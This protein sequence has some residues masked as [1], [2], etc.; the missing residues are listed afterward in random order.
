[1]DTFTWGIIGPGNI[2]TEF[3]HDLDLIKTARHRVGA[4]LSHNLD[5][6]AAFAQKEDAPQYF[7]HINDFTSQAHIDAVYIATP[8]PL[9]HSETL[10]CLQHR[11]PVLCEKPLAMNS[12]QVKEIMDAAAQH[13]TFLMEG[14]WIRFLPS[15]GKVLSLIE[16]NAIGKI[17][18]VKADMSYKAPYD[19]ASRY[20]NPE[21]GG[22]SLLDLGIYPV[23]LTHL[24]LGKPATIQATARLSDKQVDEA[25]AAVL[26]YQNGSYAFI[27]SSLVT[28]TARKATIYGE[29]GSIH[30][31]TPWNEE[32]SGIKVVSYEGGEQ[33]YPCAWEGHGL[34]YEAEE[35]YHCVQQHKLY[36]HKHSHRF[37]LEIMDTLDTI[38]RQTGIVYPADEERPVS[39]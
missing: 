36:S 32:P 34:Q 15:I 3:A 5:K 37:S 38:R 33:Q 16:S 28:K 23:F 7:E 2:A 35:V 25:C 20:F 30:I 27:E 8:H 29:T 6:A 17:I 19:P 18:S 14:M 12:R 26:S 31:G 24:L 9:H 13:Q 39:G 21:L 1:M 10:Q 22:G 11:I 4:V